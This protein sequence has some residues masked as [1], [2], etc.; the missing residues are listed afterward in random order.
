MIASEIAS[1]REQQARQE[2]AAQLGL[3]GPAIVSSHAFIEARAQAG[4]E[5]IL[6]LLA[7]GQ[8]EE[9]RRLME[10]KDWGLEEGEMQGNVPFRYDH[11][12]TER[13]NCL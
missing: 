3:S 9:A 13:R 6:W 4:A 10:Q 12:L 1:F 2:E 5:H 7:A 8:E 11:P